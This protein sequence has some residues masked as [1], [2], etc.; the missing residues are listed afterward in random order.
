[1]PR[2]PAARV[3]LAV[4]ALAGLITC[5]VLVY[6]LLRLWRHWPRVGPSRGVADALNAVVLGAG[7]AVAL[8]TVAV[9]ATVAVRGLLAARRAARWIG[10]HA[11]PPSER[12]LAIAR[13]LGG[14][15]NDVRVVQLDVDD[16]VA[17]TH[18]LV[19][20]VVA[21][22]TGLARRTTDEELAAVLGHEL[23]HARRRHPL[24]RLVV[25]TV[26]STLWFVPGPRVVAHHVKTRQELSADQA[27]LAFAAPSVVASALVKCLSDSGGPAIGTGMGGDTALAARVEQLEHGSKRFARFLR[28]C[29]LR[30][31][32]LGGMVLLGL[33]MYCCVAA[34]AGELVLPFG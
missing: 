29:Q 3:G 19:R 23:H 16:P 1:M 24:G 33:I 27:A 21:V 25:E 8:V 12:V 9:A 31:L 10:G 20:P 18:G 15:D 22:S 11:L 4:C 26:A 5:D 13:R 34:V 28:C 6:T 32:L 30:R 17:L 2:V 14:P 7:A